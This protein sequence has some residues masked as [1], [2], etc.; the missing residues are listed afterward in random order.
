MHAAV[1]CVAAL[2]PAEMAMVSGLFSS[3]RPFFADAQVGQT[4]SSDDFRCSTREVWDP[5][6]WRFSVSRVG[7]WSHQLYRGS[8]SSLKGRDITSRLSEIHPMARLRT[9]GRTK[10]HKVERTCQFLTLKP[11]NRFDV[12]LRKGLNRQIRMRRNL[13]LMSHRRKSWGGVVRGVEPRMV[14]A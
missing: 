5:G 11:P 7:K 13:G 2:D 9:R 10:L 3:I 12:R 8:L 14:R 1:R 4:G 6:P